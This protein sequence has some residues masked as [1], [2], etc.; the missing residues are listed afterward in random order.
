MRTSGW[1]AGAAMTLVLGATTDAA[2]AGNAR[3]IDPEGRGSSAAVADDGRLHLVW[4]RNPAGDG[5]PATIRYCEIPRGSTGG[6]ESGTLRDLVLPGSDS[7]ASG[8][9][10][11]HVDGSTVRV[12]AVENA[13]GKL[14]VWTS[15]DGGAVFGAP[16]LESDTAGADTQRQPG[17]LVGDELRRAFGRR[18]QR[19][20]L[21]GTANLEDGA[22]LLPRRNAPEDSGIVFTSDLD[23]EQDLGTPHVDAVASVS[24][25]ADGHLAVHRSTSDDINTAANWAGPT[26]F[27]N[28]NGGQLSGGVEGLFMVSATLD[29]PTQAQVM[30]RRWDSAL[31]AFGAPV[32]VGPPG[33]WEGSFFTNIAQSRGKVHVV[34]SGPDPAGSALRLYTSADQGATWTIATLDRRSGAFRDVHL[35]VAPDGGGWATWTEAA[36][37]VAVGDL[38][39]A[40]PAPVTPPAPQPPAPDVLAPMPP[41]PAP[42]PGRV[43]YKTL[44]KRDGGSRL[45][46]VLPRTC[47]PT[48]RGFRIG[49]SSKPVRGSRKS[50]ILLLDSEM[51]VMRNAKQT[52]PGKRRRAFDASAPFVRTLTAQGLA[53]NRQYT[54]RWRFRFRRTGGG[55]TKAQRSKVYV[56]VYTARVRTCAAGAAPTR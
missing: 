54:L 19:A 3:V 53:A 48:S 23:L 14:Y 56:G 28:E 22:A 21:G 20:Q 37:G 50:R 30:V 36:T 11:V 5:K 4:E 49:I 24:Y 31:K 8:G 55:L 35:A 41:A 39:D 29:P 12:T 26:V 16:Q 44:T 10:H 9:Q 18:V 6:C 25:D 34:T 17:V 13:E 42:G 2:L 46:F 47:V 51:R 15:T 7:N 27:A 1:M 43:L 45:T 32:S 38:T 33:P 52:L 40:P